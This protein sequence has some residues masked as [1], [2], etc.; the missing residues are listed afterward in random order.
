MLLDI[1]TITRDD[2]EGCRRTLASTR[3]LRN[4][5]G[6]RQQVVDSSTPDNQRQIEE[7]CN[8][9]GVELLMTPPLGVS[10]ALNKGLKNAKA[11]WIW[12]LHG[13]DMLHADAPVETVMALLAASRADI[14]IFQL[15][16]STGTV[17]HPPLHGLW[18]P[19]FNWIPHPALLM[20]RTILPPD[21]VFDTK[22]KV[23]MDYDLWFRLMGADAVV[24]LISL[25]LTKFAVAGLSN[26]L[27]V[28]G[29]EGREVMW[30]H[31]YILY[32]RWREMLWK[33][34]SAWSH[35]K[36]LQAGGGS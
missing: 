14:M 5:P 34:I 30:R 23:A 29:K 25:P 7:L 35:F 3:V 17:R 1:I 13:G 4:R 9:E 21:P 6:V 2:V 16:S 18:P 11:E 27:G 19:V 33:I 20:R 8:V 31:R 32:Y 12:C 22:L 15:E 24:D 28:L 36:R 10:D 26:N